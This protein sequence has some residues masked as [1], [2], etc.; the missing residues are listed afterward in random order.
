MARVRFGKVSVLL[1]TCLLTLGLAAA[2]ASAVDS[3]SALVTTVD[4][5]S[6]LPGDT[7]TI[8]MTFTNVQSTEVDFVY[9]GHIEMYNSITSNV[10][11]TMVGC[12][13]NIVRCPGDTTFFLS[14]VAPGD[15]RTQ[16]ETFQIQPDSGC[17]ESVSVSEVFYLYYEF[18][19][20]PWDGLVAGF[21]TAIPCPGP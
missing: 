18:A 14:P 1:A 5:A 15:T 8:T 2:P 4:K 11:Y 17:G 16:T 13:G 3:A 12:S 9:I 19:G 7:V 21:T 6:A 10:R 20:G